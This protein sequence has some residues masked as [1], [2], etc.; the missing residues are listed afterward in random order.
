MKEHNHF[1]EPIGLEEITYN[2]WVRGMYENNLSDPESRTISESKIFGSYKIRMLGID[3][4]DGFDIGYAIVFELTH[5]ESGLPYDSILN[6]RYC[7]YGD[8]KDWI[9]YKSLN[10]KL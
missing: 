5:R 7:K 6:P 8:P 9:V 10:L 4:Q 2:E 1:E 3:N